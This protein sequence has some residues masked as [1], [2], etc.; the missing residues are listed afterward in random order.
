MTMIS[1][2]YWIWISHVWPLAERFKKLEISVMHPYFLLVPSNYLEKLFI[3]QFLE[4][5]LTLLAIN[6]MINQQFL[7]NYFSFLVLR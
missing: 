6:A 1:T 2:Q 7:I 3:L 4:W 5:Y